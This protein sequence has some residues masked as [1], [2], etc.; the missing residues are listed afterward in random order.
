VG[1][2]VNSEQKKAGTSLGKSGVPAFNPV[3]LAGIEY[4]IPTGLWAG[5]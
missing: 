2:A 5:K 3:E 4:S 1:V